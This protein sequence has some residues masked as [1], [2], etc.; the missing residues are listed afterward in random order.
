MRKISLP[1]QIATQF[2]F[3]LVGLF[4][5]IPVWSTF[6]LA[7][8]GS[9]RGRPTEFTWLPKEFSTEAFLTVLDRP[10]QSVEFSILLRNSMIV[11]IGAAVLAVILG[12]TLAYGFARFRFPAKQTGL[13]V[14]LLAALLPPIAFATPLYIIL[15]L[16]KIRTTLIGLVIV[17]AAFAMP[18]AIWNMRAA[19]AA[20]PKEVEE[21]AYIDG[22]SHFQTFLNISL[23][24]SLPSISVTAMIAFLMGYTEFAIGW[25]FVDKA[26]NVT[27]S[28]AVY[29][30]VN[31]QFSGAQPWS[32]LGSLAIIMSIPVM[33][34][35]ILFQQT[36]MER[37]L[38]QEPS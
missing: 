29:A 7:F 38:F 11:S 21:A 35:F 30:L 2:I 13:F 14:L 17:Y 19:F 20:I 16:L 12:L 25:L 24:I 36:L 9:L 37:L 4:I 31:G 28:M 27:L 1:R 5:L 3:L 23:P 15:S 18:F 26:D 6:R 32:Y 10:Y 33:V 34:I 8:D 22:A